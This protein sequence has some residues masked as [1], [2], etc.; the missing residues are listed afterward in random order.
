MKAETLTLPAVR[1][2]LT[3][4]RVIIRCGDARFLVTRV[5]FET[6]CKNLGRPPSFFVLYDENRIMV[7][8]ITQL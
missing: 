5:S 6:T 3:G 1:K 8:K 7:E 4:R 2:L